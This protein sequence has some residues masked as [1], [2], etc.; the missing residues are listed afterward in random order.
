MFKGAGTSSSGISLRTH[1]LAGLR[2]WVYRDV[3]FLVPLYA[4]FP[5]ATWLVASGCLRCGVF[6]GSPVDVD[7]SNDVGQHDGKLN[8]ASASLVYQFP[9]A[10]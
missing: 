6:L 1:A 4:A 9:T 10:R 2:A 5:M 7:T 8:C 3:E